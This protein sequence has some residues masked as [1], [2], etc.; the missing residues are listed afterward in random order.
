LFSNEKT[1]LEKQ[2]EKSIRAQVRRAGIAAEIVERAMPGSRSDTV[3]CISDW[4]VAP[5]AVITW[6]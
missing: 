5:R 3:G 6:I 4:A 1:D 2:N